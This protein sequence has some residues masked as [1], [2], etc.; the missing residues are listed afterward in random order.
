CITCE[1][2]PKALSLIEK[3]CAQSGTKLYRF[4]KDFCL[5][6][7]TSSFLFCGVGRSISGITI[8][9]KGEHQRRNSTG[10]I[11]IALAIEDAGLFPVSDE[12][13]RNGLRKSV[14]HGRFEIVLQK[15]LVVIDGAHNIA[16]IRALIKTLKE[17]FGSV[18]IIFIVGFLREK[19]YRQMVKMIAPV[20]KRII[21]TRPDSPRAVHPN[22]LLQISLL[23][24]CDAIVHENI[25]D[26]LEIALKDVSN[27]DII[28]V[29]GS[30]FLVG[31][32]KKR[33]NIAC[34]RVSQE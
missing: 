15:P 22:E 10:A 12:A 20:S 2:N 16:G 1:Q 30:L 24:N 32:I 4:G 6:K 18:R 26:A 33:F 17:E 19:K 34:C 27:D 11:A 8:P 13:I 28:C 7:Q 25:D 31:A 9:L 23:Y 21:F 14:W 5:Q 29:T 3:V